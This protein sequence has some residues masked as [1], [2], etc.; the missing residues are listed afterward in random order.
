MKLLKQNF[1]PVDLA[2]KTKKVRN[3]IAYYTK[4]TD[5]DTFQ[6][7]D[8]FFVLASTSGGYAENGIGFECLTDDVLN[9]GGKSKR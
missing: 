2:S 5:N 6:F 3:S 1:L 4:I 7:V 9:L 8:A